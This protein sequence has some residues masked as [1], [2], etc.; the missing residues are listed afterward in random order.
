MDSEPTSLALSL[1]NRLVDELRADGSKPGDRVTERKIAERL[2][3]SRSPIRGALHLL[4]QAGVLSQG[5]RGYR[6]ADLS[7]ADA[8]PRL[9]HQHD[10]DEAVYLRIADD[11]LSE[12]L[13]DRITENELMRRYDLTRTRLV[14][15]LRRMAQEGWVERLPG[16]GWAFLP[17]LTSL[18]AY[19]DSYRFRLII[20]P[21]A[22]LEPRWTLDRAALE[23]RRVEQVW[24][25]E[26][27]V[28][29]VSGS[30]LF[31]MNS[32][33]HE[34]IME[35][36]GN[37]FFIE[38]LRRVDR[39]R[40]LIDYR[41]ALDREIALERCKEHVAILDLVLAKRTDEASAFMQ[42]HLSDLHGLKTVARKA[43]SSDVSLES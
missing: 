39:L 10:S 1:A 12:R 13:P 3:V 37:A 28:F 35:C 9:K 18:E 43:Q 8:L 14:R 23:A 11:R 27:G 15:T 33:M 21:A 20:E 32:G 38:S 25:V 7:S 22:L 40:R 26:G 19:E 24:L 17:V 31:E 42:H 29:A 30:R 36:C 34:A 2:R 6:V 41:Q 5:E 16:H 4:A